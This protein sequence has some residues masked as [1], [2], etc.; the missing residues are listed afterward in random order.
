MF[1][2]SA[3]HIAHVNKRGK[4]L[5][6]S[7][8]TGEAVDFSASLELTVNR[9]N[10]ISLKAYME[11]VND[12]SFQTRG[13]LCWSKSLTIKEVRIVDIEKSFFSYFY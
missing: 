7:P 9:R 3:V 6:I 10:R 13:K 1:D 2:G 11:T 12:L 5:K 4:R 8:Q